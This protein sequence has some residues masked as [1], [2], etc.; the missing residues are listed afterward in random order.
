ME[1]LQRAIRVLS[2]REIHALLV[3]LCAVAS[4]QEPARRELLM[5]PDIPATPGLLSVREAPPESHDPRHAWERFLLAVQG[6]N[7]GFYD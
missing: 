6:A 4:D 7:D 5:N 3:L 1:L 2:I